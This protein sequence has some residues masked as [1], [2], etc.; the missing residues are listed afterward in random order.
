MDVR[1]WVRMRIVD[2]L[3]IDAPPTGRWPVEPYRLLHFRQIGRQL[4]HYRLKPVGSRV[5]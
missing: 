3:A 5:S 4:N 2:P 1:A